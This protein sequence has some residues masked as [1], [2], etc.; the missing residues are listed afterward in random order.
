MHDTL[1][2]FVWAEMALKTSNH[3]VFWDLRITNVLLFI[4]VWDND[5][6]W[7]LIMNY[8]FIEDWL[9]ARWQWGGINQ[10]MPK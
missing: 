8:S 3:L 4:G 1:Y 10:G 2:Y 6:S 9:E 5:V 7:Y